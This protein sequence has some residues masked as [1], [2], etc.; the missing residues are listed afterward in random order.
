[1][2]GTILTVGVVVSA[3]VGG[4]YAWLGRRRETEE[5]YYFRC[6]DCG[7]KMR[8]AA[9]KAGRAAMCPRCHQRWVLPATPEALGEPPAERAH[10]IGRAKP[11]RQHADAGRCWR[12][13]V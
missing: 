9:Q 13:A 2:I 12:H 6:P 4:G 7:Q 8:Y 3:A 11:A 5:L 10:R 1:M